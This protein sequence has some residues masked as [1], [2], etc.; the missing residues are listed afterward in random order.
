[1]RHSLLLLLLCLFTNVSFANSSL[2]EEQQLAETI[3]KKLFNTYGNF[4]YPIPPKIEVVA[5]KKRVAAFVADKQSGKIILEK[6]V[7][8]ICKSFGKDA[9]SALAFVIGHE[10]G[11]F[12]ERTNNKGFATNYLK[13]T[14]TQKEEEKADILGVFCAYLA[15]YKTTSIVP[16]LI[17]KIYAEYGLMDKKDNLYGYPT[18]KVRQASAQNVQAKVDEL[19]HLFDTANYLSTVGKYK[20]AAS[21]YQYILQFYKGREIYN[22]LGVN[23]ALEAMNFTKK[24]VDI[25]LYP[26][27]IDAQTRLRRPKIDRGGEDLTKAEQAYRMQMLDN[28]KKYLKEVGKIDFNY[29]IDDINMIS[30]LS[31]RL[32]L[33]KDCESP[34]SYYK[35]NQLMKTASFMGADNEQK[36]KLKLALAIAYVKTGKKE[37]AKKIWE[38]LKSHPNAQISYQATYNLSTLKEDYSTSFIKIYDSPT[39]VVEVPND[40]VRLHRVE[41]EAGFILDS[42]QGI[43]AEIRPLKNSTLTIFES[44]DGETFIIQSWTIHTDKKL[45]LNESAKYQRVSNSKGFYL[46]DMASSKAY[47][48]NPEGELKEYIRFYEN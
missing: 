4:V 1:M 18:F 8:D 23:Y 21:S 6:A 10:L 17:E 2:I 37:D 34:V 16:Q 7:F 27:E 40:N 19:I 28:A 39:V 29:L 14:H 48:V 35:K 45:K 9:E 42:L 38:S 31:L 15:D 26:F 41:I 30:V 12:Y 44:D 11:H 43:E 13:W 25:Y 33:C 24:N 5:E 46:V 20:L 36:A 3:L 22:N 32:D 47:S